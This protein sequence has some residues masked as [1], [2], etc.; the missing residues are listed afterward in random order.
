MRPPTRHT[1]IPLIKI[2]LREDR[3]SHDLTSRAVLPPN[4]R[5][6]A[7]IIAKASGILAG[8][9]VAGWVFQVFD[10]SLRCRLAAKEGSHLKRSQTILIVEG[11]ARS[12]LAAERTALNLLGHLCGIATLTRE[13]VRRTR[14]TRAKILDTRKTLP[15]LRLLE[16]YAVR[17][18]GGRNHR[19]GLD[20]AIL[21]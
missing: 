19:A 18:G 14:G 5:I 13:Y 7:R 3:A 8:G 1:I 9:P 10:P 17:V 6:R 15:S 21:I 4:T 11:R 12:I 2:A 16:K 20:E